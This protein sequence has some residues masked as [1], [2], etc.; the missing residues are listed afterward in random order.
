MNNTSQSSRTIISLATTLLLLTLSSVASAENWAGWRGPNRNGVS[1]EKGIPIRWSAGNGVRWKMPLPGFGISNPI[2]WGD[3]VIITASSGPRLAELHVICLSRETGTIEW[4]RKFWGT[5]PTRH[6]NN[7]SSMA[8]PAPVTDGKHVFA[9]FG[10]G[11]V[12]CLE[13]DGDLVWQRS[14]ASEYG[15]FENRFAASSSPLLYGDL[16]LLQCDHYGDSYLVALEKSSGTNRWKAD[17][18]GYW[19]SW[20]SPQ[21]VPVAGTDRHEF[22]VSGSQKLEGYDS[23]TGKKLWTV[24]GMR[25]ECIPT[26]LF[27]NGLIYAVSGPKGP[28]LAIRP[29]GRGDVTDTR[30]LWSN[31]RGAPFVPSAILVDQNYFLIDDQGIGTCL[32]LRDGKSQWQKRFGGKFTASPVVAEGRVYFC[33]EAGVTTVI[34]GTA[35]EYTEIAKNDVGE[36]I[37]ASPAISQGCLFLRTVKHLIC[38]DGK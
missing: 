14:L 36:P 3:R 38:V 17:R 28:S 11:D 4:Q 26:P 25:R 33:D 13:M 37:F 5:S 6:H 7:K 8:S 1:S 2:V 19:L 27:A 32:N 24:G 30:V 34:D 23:A 22:V 9:F 12:F 35:A 10:T 20:A 21:L 16:L 31:T 15:I 18:P 29:G